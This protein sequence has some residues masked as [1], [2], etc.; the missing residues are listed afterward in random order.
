MDP[1]ALLYIDGAW[2]KAAA[3]GRSGL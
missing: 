1:D 2:T 3:S